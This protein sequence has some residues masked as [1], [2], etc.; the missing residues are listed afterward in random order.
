MS[1]E[2]HPLISIIVP[3]YKVEKYLE[4]CVK[5]ILSQTYS[6]FELILVDD[7]SPDNCPSMCDGF[8]KM[9][10]RI[11][12]VHK[13]NGGLSDARN[14]GLDIAKGDYIGFVDSDDYIAANMYEVLLK[15]TLKN[16]A[17]LALCNYVRV[18]ENDEEI[19][20]DTIQ[21]HAIDRKYNRY[22]FIH[23]LIK[24]YGGYYIVVWNKLYKRSIFHKLR[25]PVGKQHED[26]YV[27]HYIIDK[28]DIIV[29]VKEDLYYYVQ[30]NGSIMSKKFNVKN[31][32]Y[33]EALIDRYHFTK[34]KKYGEWQKQCVFKLSDQFDKWKQYASKDEEIK[35][36]YD[37]LR[38]RSK[39]LIFEKSAWS[40][41]GMTLKGKLFMRI[42]HI[43]PAFSKVVRKMTHKGTE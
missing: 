27:I 43:A 30:R 33:G 36:K 12:V 11:V 21:K 19:I 7:G 5:S 9:D 24:P 2:T 23:E 22:E 16:D 31:L 25:F 41:E 39:F 17:D 35:K 34:S 42:E 1:P 29:S 6:N 20:S 37:E 28:C 13:E 26:E 14:A 15:T 4:K 10:P 32:D 3:V 8:A 18:N 38:R 40:R